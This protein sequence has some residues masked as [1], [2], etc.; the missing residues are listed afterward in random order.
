MFFPRNH[1]HWLPPVIPTHHF[2]A[3]SLHAVLSL[4]LSAVMP[5]S[6]WAG[7]VAVLVYAEV[8]SWWH[9][10][11]IPSLCRCTLCWCC[12]SCLQGGWQM[13]H[14]HSWGCFEAVCGACE[15]F[16]GVWL[17]GLLHF[18]FLQGAAPCKTKPCGIPGELAVWCGLEKAQCFLTH[19]PLHLTQTHTQIYTEEQFE[20][21][22][23]LKL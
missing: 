21:L 6:L 7:D 22:L 16:V 11:I 20:L 15:T 2:L 14:S 23:S 19:S 9:I 3:G 12:K 8:C 18:I 10:P 1:L 4:V 13:W 17:W 5:S